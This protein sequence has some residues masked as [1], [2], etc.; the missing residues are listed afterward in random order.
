MKRATILLADDHPMMSAAL[1]KMLEEDY[2]VVGSASDGRSLVMMAFDLKPDL[3]VL[4]VGLPVL[5]G[6]EAGRHLKARIPGVK[7]VY[8]TMNRDPEIAREAFFIGAAGFVFKDEMGEE[9][10][11]VIQNALQRD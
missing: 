7:L 2:D 10:L 11:F 6:L 9:L 1:R 4:D 3:V 5:N 8:L